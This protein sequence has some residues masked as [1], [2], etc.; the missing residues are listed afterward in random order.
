MRDIYYVRYRTFFLYDNEHSSKYINE[1]QKSKLNREDAKYAKKNIFLS[2]NRKAK[3]KN[4]FVTAAFAKS[5][6][7]PGSSQRTSAVTKVMAGQT[8]KGK[9][10]LLLRTK[11]KNH[12]KPL[13]N[14]NRR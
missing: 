6:I 1:K 13:M 7:G 10:F 14:A 2:K 5:F 11:N 4:I 3:T 8:E 12:I 9:D